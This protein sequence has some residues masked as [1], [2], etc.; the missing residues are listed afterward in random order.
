MAS[1]KEGHPPD[2]KLPSLKKVKTKSQK[3]MKIKNT[4]VYE[5]NTK[6][7]A[8]LDIAIPSTS[9]D[10]QATLAMFLGHLKYIL[11]VCVL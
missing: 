6:P 4:H 7:L 1:L 11:E 9:S 8:E 3:Q 2:V 10:A 5:F